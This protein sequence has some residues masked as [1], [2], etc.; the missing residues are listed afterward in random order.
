MKCK[1]RKDEAPLE[2]KAK[3]AAP[4]AA[5]SSGSNWNKK[6]PRGPKKMALERDTNWMIENYEGEHV[7]LEEATM[8]QLVCIINC[9]NATVHIKNKVKNIGIDGCQRV[10]IVCHDVVSTVE[11]V[12]CDNCKLFTQ[13]K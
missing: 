4:K 13:G 7:V 2:P 11:F 12:N 9:K 1:N 8:Q 10:N 6:G 5:A 3:A